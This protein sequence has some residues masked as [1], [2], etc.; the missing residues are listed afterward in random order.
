VLPRPT[1]FRRVVAA[2]RLPQLCSYP[3]ENTMFEKTGTAS[4]PA[5][6]TR[7]RRAARIRP[8]LR[9]LGLSTTALLLLGSAAACDSSSAALPSPAPSPLAAANAR[10]GPGGNLAALQAITAAERPASA[11]VLAT[12]PTAEAIDKAGVLVVG[13]TET[14][15]LFSLLDPSTG[16]VTG[17]DAE[18]SQL[19]A[20]YIIGQPITKL[21]QVTAQTR[22]ALLEAHSVDAVFATYTITAA[23][24]KEV[25]FAGPY[26]E[27]GLAIMVRR[28]TTGISS[29]AELDGKTVVTESGSTVPSAV[30]AQA[31]SASIQLFDTNTECLQALEE[32]RADA[33]VIDQGI[34]AGDAAQSSSVEVLPGIFTREPY[35][36]GLSLEEPDFKAFVDAW[37]NQIERDGTWAKVWQATIGT[38]VP[39]NPPAPPQIG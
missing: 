38:S 8:R 7:V 25:A 33:Y 10:P 36:I 31:P 11:A 32:G 21:V 35:G 14:A 30:K 17:F 2:L 19:L 39:G 29:M 12:S 16:K 1:D 13:G 18:L 20:K 15:D 24:E 22:E 5:S 3:E 4:V 37:L 6:R 27:D 23:R 9:R 34:L 28:G 26:Y